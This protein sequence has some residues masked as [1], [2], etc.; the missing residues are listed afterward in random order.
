MGG[1]GPGR[2]YRGTGGRGRGFSR[3]CLWWA[4]P[5]RHEVDSSG[6]RELMGSEKVLGTVG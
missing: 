6:R 1:S 4:E 3:E 2:D 5:K